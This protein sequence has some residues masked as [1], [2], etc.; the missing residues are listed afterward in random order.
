[1]KLEE[2]RGLLRKEIEVICKSHDWNVNDNKLRGMAFEDWCFDFFATRYPTAENIKTDSTLRTN[3]EGIDVVFESKDTEEVFLIQC[4]HPKIAQTEPIVE[5]EVIRFFSAFNL[6]TD[7]E[8]QKKITNNSAR[9]EELKSELD[10]WRRQNFTITLLFISNGKA[11][12]NVVA[13]AEKYS[14]SHI[15]DNVKF[16]VW[17]LSEL[18]DAYVESKSVEE[19]YP[20]RIVINVPES[21]YFCLPG[22]EYKNF[23]FA[24][25]GNALADIARRHKETLFNW[26]I[27]RYLGK[28]GQVNKGMTETISAHPQ[29]FFYFNNGISALCQTFD[30]DEAKRV[31]T[32]HKMQIVNGAQTV[33]ASRTQTPRG[34]RTCAYL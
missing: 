23:T 18:K 5:D 15:E 11:T 28:K 34:S 30:F 3:D 6:L 20:E 4:K 26:N 12:E 32:I 24:L 25:S 16:E 2:F 10:Y 31:L 21:G 27:R 14:K 29:H 1:M 7:V 22:L 13:L 8:H 9:I 33:G 19:A 17:G